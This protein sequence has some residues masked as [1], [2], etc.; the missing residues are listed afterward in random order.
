M[1][2]ILNVICIVTILVVII[3]ALAWIAESMRVARNRK[4]FRKETNMTRAEYKKWIHEINN[5][6]KE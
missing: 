5:Q 1:D 6:T 3:C 4:Q 2:T